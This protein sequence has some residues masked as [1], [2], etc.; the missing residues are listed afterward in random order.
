M[1]AYL[2]QMI[3]NISKRKLIVAT[4]LSPV[5]GVGAKCQISDLEICNVTQI[6]SVKVGKIVIIKDES[7]LI[8]ALRRWSGNVSVGGG[9]Y[10]MGGQVGIENGLHLD[11]RQMN[12]LI[13]LDVANKIAVVQ[14][15]MKWR[16]LQE[17]IDKYDLSV[18]TMQSYSNFTVGGSVSVNC[19]GGYVGHGSIQESLRKIKIALP[20]GELVIAS[21]NKN[22]E[23]FAAAVGGYGAVGVILEIELQLDDNFKI[24]KIVENV[25]VKEYTDWF[26]E[27]IRGDRNVL[28]HNADLQSPNFSTPRCVS[29]SRTDGK[30]TN[31]KRLRDVGGFYGLEKS[32]LWAI[33]EAPKGEFLRNKIINKIQV[34]I[35]LVIHGEDSKHQK[36]DSLKVLAGSCFNGN[37]DENFTELNILYLLHKQRS[38]AFHQTT[39]DAL[40]L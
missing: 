16:D 2:I 13:S 21:R 37:T 11:M 25:N 22:K 23:L 24:E 18:R 30:L 31:D 38:P 9:R 12:G 34:D 1:S 19:H 39:R 36:R 40:A 35:L 26:N 15:G 20:T 33:T 17:I 10:S 6:N 14:A 8:Y 7:E 5:F 28:L 27:K 32:A 29:W 4:A 3:L